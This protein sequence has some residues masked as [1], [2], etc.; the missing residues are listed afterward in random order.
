MPGKGIFTQCVSVLFSRDP[1][2]EQLEASLSSFEI[3]GRQTKNPSWPFSGP[4][5]TVA[6]RPEINGF[7]VVDIVNHSW[8]DSM[9]EAR[10]DPVLFGAW[11][12]GNFGP[13]THPGALARAT[14]QSLLWNT[15]G[16]MASDHEAFIRIR[17]SYVLGTQGEEPKLPEG[18]QAFDELLF[19]TRI[20]GLLLQLPGA[21]CYFNPNGE[22]LQ[23]LQGLRKS[24]ALSQEANF[25]P[26]DLWINSRLYRLVDQWNFMDTVGNHQL[27][28]PDLEI[29]FPMHFDSTEIEPFLRSVTWYLKQQESVQNG[30]ILSGPQ[31]SHWQVQHRSS[32]Y[33]DPPRS[34]LRLTPVGGPPL[35]SVMEGFY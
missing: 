12:L 3:R 16:D 30:D 18:Y 20:V 35:P 26:L 34:V 11:S 9:G 7:M 1:S 8:P 28:V 5:I 23:D 24:L 6:F 32:S 31:Q 33:A 21:L 2:L 29:C 14:Q 17:S 22:I 10:V 4:S 27:D 15:H 13:F 19:M 25:P